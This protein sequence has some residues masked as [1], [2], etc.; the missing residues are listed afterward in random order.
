MMYV[1]VEGFYDERFFSKV[2]HKELGEAKFVQYSGMTTSKV[3]RFIKS[4]CCMPNGNYLFFG[5]ADGQ[6]IEGKKAILTGRYNQLDINK[7]FIVQYEIESWYYAGASQTLCQKLNLKYYKYYTD[8][9]T[10]EGFNHKLPKIAERKTIM[11]EILNQYDLNLA[12]GRNKSLS[13]FEEN[14]KKESA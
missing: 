6:T 9:L 2:Y 7:L 11:G 3:N 10:K 12:V 13:I 8:N 4:I 1:F 5:D 14:I